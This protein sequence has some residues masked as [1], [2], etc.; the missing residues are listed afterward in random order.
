MYS[1]IKSHGSNLS[2]IVCL[3]N[4]YS[5]ISYSSVLHLVIHLSISITFDRQSRSAVVQN[6]RSCPSLLNTTL[7]LVVSHELFIPRTD[8]RP[9]TQ[10]FFLLM[11]NAHA[12][13]PITSMIQRSCVDYNINRYRILI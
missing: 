11:H 12:D 8:I 9:R 6:I 7:P 2:E 13:I 3:I 10:F 1:L 5:T 4:E